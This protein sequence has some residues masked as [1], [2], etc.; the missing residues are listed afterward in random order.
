MTW[1]KSWAS[2]V[3]HARERYAC[4][5]AS[6][7]FLTEPVMDWFL[8]NYLSD[9]AH[10]RD[11]KGSPIM[12]RDLSGLPPAHV[13]TAGFDPLRD[14]GEAYAD[15]LRAAGVPT[16]SRCYDSLI[17]GFV[18]MGGIVDAARH[19]LDDLGDVLHRALWP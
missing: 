3:W 5:F 18:S 14:E 1:R 16:T 10:T 12:T 2:S 4:T 11:P 13:V 7:F 19:A 17:H 15:A 6:G 8:A 9:P